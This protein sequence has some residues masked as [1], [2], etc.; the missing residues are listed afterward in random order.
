M[1]DSGVNVLNLVRVPVSSNAPRHSLS[2]KFCTVNAQSVRN[3]TGCL[4]DFIDENDVNLC[5]ITESWLTPDD[6]VIRRELKIDGYKLECFNR[7]DRT[8]GGIAVLYKEGLKLEKVESGETNSYEFIEMILL[9]GTL[10]VRLLS[11]YRP[12][13]GSVGAF[14]ESFVEHLGRVSMSSGNL[15]V[16]G[17]FNIHVNKP[18]CTE[19]C[20]FLE[21]VLV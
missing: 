16:C 19:A 8:G 15:L 1:F 13:N 17:D 5:V 12:P 21:L 2:L 18:D 10:S 4:I 11:V 14:M 6:A 3:K 20:Q 9:H 7:M